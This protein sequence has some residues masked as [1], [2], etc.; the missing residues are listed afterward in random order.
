MESKKPIHEIKL[1]RIRA[2]IW[3]NTSD[4]GEPWF[5]VTVNRIY[6]T[7]TKWKESTSFRRDDLPVVM[8]AF[9]MAHGWIWRAQLKN[10]RLAQKK[11]GQVTQDA[12]G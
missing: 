12:R 7:G 1:G 8:K 10:E 4:D 5:N 2:A 6:K 11:N 9:D 3:T